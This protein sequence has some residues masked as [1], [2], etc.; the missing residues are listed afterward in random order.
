M[1]IYIAGAA[2]SGKSTTGRIVS[3]KI[4]IPFHEVEARKC[5][6]Y[7]DIVIRQRCFLS[8]FKKKMSKGDGIY[9]NH[10]LS[11]YGYS[12]ALG[13]PVDL[14]DSIVRE[15]REY[16]PVILFV[17]SREELRRRILGRMTI[18]DERRTNWVESMI[19]VHMFAQDVML[20]YARI[21][22]IPIIDT[23]NKS[24]DTVA[25]EV[26]SVIEKLGT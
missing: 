10:L 5:W 9:S 14:A 24:V 13:L 2:G 21:N 22:G 23:S 1:R 25:K 8:E 12:I 17:V 7:T 15:E 20:K 3:R 26:L 6:R 11:V 16:R 18:D 4:G 19:D